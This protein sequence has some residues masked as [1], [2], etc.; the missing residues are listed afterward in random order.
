[1]SNIYF[2]IIA[3]FYILKHPEHMQSFRKEF[4][5]EP[6]INNIFNTVKDFVGDYRTEP[7]AEQVIELI[8]LAGKSDEVSDDSIKMLWNNSSSIKQ[9]GED[10]LETNILGWGKW[11]S[12]Y[13]GLEK[14]I[15]Y[16]QTLPQNISFTSTDDYISQ[17]KNIFTNGTNF[18]A[19][20]GSGH[21]FFEIE[22]HQRVL[23]NTRSSGYNF[24]D[25][26]L[27][28]GFS[29]KT[30]ICF[31]GPPKVGK[32][33]WLCNIAAKS[34]KNGYN[35]LYISLEMAYQLVAQRIGSNLYN[36]NIKEYNELTK[37][38][39]AFKQ[40]IDASKLGQ[41]NAQP[42]GKFIIEEFPTSTMTAENIEAFALSLEQKYSTPD[43]PFKFHN[44]VIDYI[45]I[46]KDRKN[47][48]SENMYQKIKSI[49][50]DVRAVAQRNEWCIISATQT[51]RGG[52]DASDL[53]MSNVSESTGL[54]AT[55]DALFGI[56]RTPVMMAENCYYLKALALRDSEN[57]GDKKRFDIDPSHLRIEENQTE[58]IIAENQEIPV[59]LRSA[60]FNAVH[61]NQQSQQYPQQQPI[62]P[63]PKLGITE[64]QI[65]GQQLFGL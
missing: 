28:G 36:I 26:A 38:P 13:T 23:L 59:A 32:S 52:M 63:A 47:P 60:T 4:F 7:T 27:N 65:T 46:M 12:F 30:L 2:E 35:T 20:V 3:F 33:M 39:T 14:T 50:E 15:A 42:Y 8:K 44:I 24:I 57:M 54:I 31:M 19:N 17:A 55:V 6:T 56:I 58:G 40:R 1:M 21:D 49:C 48:N 25:L 37:D 18:S 61:K 51:N 41:L 16:I 53:T 11:R 43:K 29:N 62:M 9:Y 64:T 5:T 10:W 45:N 34:V 22:T